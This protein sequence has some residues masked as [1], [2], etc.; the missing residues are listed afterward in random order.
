M[1]KGREAG[2]QR[3]NH[4]SGI[5]YGID[6]TAVVCVVSPDIIPITTCPYNH[7]VRT[8]RF[9]LSYISTAV[10]TFLSPIYSRGAAYFFG[11]TAANS[12]GIHTTT[13]VQ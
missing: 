9:F 7:Y 3:E 2:V 12:L 13:V 5:A 4:V 6:E 11:L 1:G 8:I 10:L